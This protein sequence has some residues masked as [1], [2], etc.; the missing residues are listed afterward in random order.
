MSTIEMPK[1]YL[2]Q[3]EELMIGDSILITEVKR[4]VWANH[5]SAMHRDTNKQ[6][7]I[8]TNRDNKEIRVW[9]LKDIT[10]AA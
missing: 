4:Q 6:F 2:E 10:T 3:L 9:R 8:R 1:T 7:T 5:I